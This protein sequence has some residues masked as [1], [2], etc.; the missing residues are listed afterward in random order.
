MNGAGGVTGSA[1][2]EELRAR[3]S[4]SSSRAANSSSPTT[5]PTSQ[6]RYYLASVA[7]KIYMQPE[8][9]MEWA[10]LSM[11]LIFYKGLLD[12]LDLQGGSFPPDGLQYKSAVEPFIP[13]EDVRPT[14]NRCRHWSARC[15]RSSRESVA[16]ARGIDT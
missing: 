4:W 9:M 12:K 5:K 10:G 3:R 2:L 1:I 8:G 7:D 13:G 15:G 6:G 11:N 16:E 14:A